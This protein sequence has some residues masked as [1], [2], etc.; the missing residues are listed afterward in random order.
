MKVKF[1]ARLIFKPFQPARNIKVLENNGRWQNVFISFFGRRQKLEHVAFFNKFEWDYIMPFGFSIY[2]LMQILD[3]LKRDF[4]SEQL[5][6]MLGWL[7]CMRGHDLEGLIG[8]VLLSSMGMF[9]AK[10]SHVPYSWVLRFWYKKLLTIE[11]TKQLCFIFCKLK[12]HRAF[13]LYAFWL[14]DI[15]LLSNNCF[16]S[17]NSSGRN[18]I[19][20]S[21]L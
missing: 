5:S 18:R 1:V 15:T 11:T 21:K 13:L 9:H 7:Q 2:I 19:P 16:I 17:S 6:F 20:F 4:H 14:Y 3:Q 12:G 8:A 10:H